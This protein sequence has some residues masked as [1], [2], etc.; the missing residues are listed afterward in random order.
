M[1]HPYDYLARALAMAETPAE[2]AAVAAALAGYS[3]HGRRAPLI[4]RAPRPIACDR[5]HVLAVFGALHPPTPT[6]GPSQ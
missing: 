3:L 6:V 2:R 1:P 5:S 4:R